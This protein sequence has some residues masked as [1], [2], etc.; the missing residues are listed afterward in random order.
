MCDKLKFWQLI[1]LTWKMTSITK[2]AIFFISLKLIILMTNEP[3]K[4]VQ[5]KQDNGFI[6]PMHI[7][8]IP[9]DPSL[10]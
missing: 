8:N 2:W 4:L 5:S 10:L 7:I 6:I 3:L 9:M 1:T